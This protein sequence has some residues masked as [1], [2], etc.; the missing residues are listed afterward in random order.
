MSNMTNPSTSC[1]PVVASIVTPMVATVV[2]VGNSTPDRVKKIQERLKIE[3]NLFV[4]PSEERINEKNGRPIRNRR[5][6]KRLVMPSAVKVN[7]K[8]HQE[9]SEEEGNIDMNAY[10]KQFE[11]CAVFTEEDLNDMRKEDDE[12]DEVENNCNEEFDEKDAEEESDEEEEEDDDDDSD[13][14]EEEESSRG[15]DTDDED[16]DLIRYYDKMPDAVSEDDE[17]ENEQETEEEDDDYVEDDHKRV[18]KKRKQMD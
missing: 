13:W 1:E 8:K 9:Y 11:E 17:D 6:P 10:D 2:V 18:N 15:E 14:K 5:P 3:N 16:S 4:L 12:I 7:D